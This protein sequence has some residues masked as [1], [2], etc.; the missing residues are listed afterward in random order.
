[1]DQHRFD[2]DL[3]DFGLGELTSE[4]TVLTAF[5]WAF[6]RWVAAGAEAPIRR[7]LNLADEWLEALRHL[8]ARFES[9]V[10]TTASLPAFWRTFFR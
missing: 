3:A 8:T 5:G 9:A 10:S 2:E 6:N 7:A 1:M 4:C